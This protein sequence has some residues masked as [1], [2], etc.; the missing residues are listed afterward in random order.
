MIA[1]QRYIA[2]GLMSGTSVDGLDI[3]ICSFEYKNFN[4]SFEILYTSSF[5]YPQN[6]RLNLINIC[7]CSAKE[8]IIIEKIF[9]EFAAVSINNCIEQSKIKPNIIASHGHTVFHKPDENYTYQIGNGELIAKLTG[10]PVVC[11]FR[12][13]DVALGGQGAPLVPIGDKL[14][15]SNYPACL[16]LGGFSN[17]S[18]NDKLG[19]RIAYDI[20]PVNIIFNRFAREL[21]FEFD[22]DGDI[23]KSGVLIPNLFQKLNKLDFYQQKH[24]KS[25]SVEWVKQ[26]VNPILDKF[27]NEKTSDIMHTCSKHIAHVLV[28]EI[29]PH[30]LVL[31]TGGGAY[32]KFLINNIKELSSSKIEIPDAKII[33]FKEALIFAF[34]GV[35]RIRSETNVLCSVTGAKR[36]SCCGVVCNP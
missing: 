27:K 10:I 28:N 20:S 6:L 19:K 8:I 3:A 31:I 22:K 25:L 1:S 12:R 17:I 35:L 2:A 24:P 23:A 7:D 18:Y 32:N 5:E 9:S 15:F 14:L 36:D 30:K 4:W 34:L 16:N 26:N 13:G 21:N 29:K 33:D 11:D